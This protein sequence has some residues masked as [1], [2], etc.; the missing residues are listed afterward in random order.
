M[1]PREAL[2]L[3]PMLLLAAMIAALA[4]GAPEIVA[5][6]VAALSGGCIAAYFALN[7]CATAKRRSRR[8]QG[9]AIG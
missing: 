8:S 9:P 3:V 1:R 5:W 2:L 6:G 7:Q 4:L